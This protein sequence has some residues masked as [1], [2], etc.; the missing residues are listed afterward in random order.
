MPSFLVP[1]NWGEFQHYK[2]RSP[3]WIRLHKKLLDDYDYQSLPIASRAL[4]PMLWLLASDSADLKS[5]AIEFAPEK[6]AFRLRMAEKDLVDALK[7]LLD[8][9]FFDVSGDAI[10]LLAECKQIAVPETETET[11]TEKR[12]RQKKA[13]VPR[14]D[15]QAHLESLGVDSLVARD[16][17]TLRKAKKAEPT[18]TAFAGVKAEADKA[19]VSLEEAIR[20]CCMRGWAGFK[21]SWLHEQ[22]GIRMNGHSSGVGARNDAIVAEYLARDAGAPSD[23]MTIEME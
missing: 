15:A 4:A 17:L 11:E 1:K 21:A 20:T 16:W 7:P 9:G 19:G 18:E 6:I 23:S 3:P 2:D 22:V 14:F 12:Q 13:R 5:G 8:K 10:D